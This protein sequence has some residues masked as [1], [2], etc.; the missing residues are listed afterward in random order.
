[1]FF[2]ILNFFLF[3]LTVI[4]FYYV[5][6]SAYLNILITIIRVLQIYIFIQFFAKLRIVYNFYLMETN[7]SFNMIYV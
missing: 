3:Y 7:N 6:Q 2:G 4:L 5:I 1:M